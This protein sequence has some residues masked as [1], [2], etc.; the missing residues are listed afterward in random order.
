MLVAIIDTGI[1]PGVFATGPIVYDLEVTPL[2]IVRKRKGQIH[3]FHGAV[4]AAIL[5]KYAPGCSICS[6]K[7]NPDN[8]LQ[9]ATCGPSLVSS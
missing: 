6:I 3:S 8:Y 1:Q 7:R 2:G 4:V 5:E 9:N